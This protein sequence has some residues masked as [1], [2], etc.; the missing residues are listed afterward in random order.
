M[1]AGFK[2]HFCV[3]DIFFDS[4]IF[5]VYMIYKAVCRKFFCH[6]YWITAH[7]KRMAGIKIKTDDF[8]S[9]FME[10]ADCAYIVNKIVRMVFNS[11]LFYSMRR[12]FFGSFFPPR[13]SYGIPLIV[14]HVCKIVWPGICYPYRVRRIGA[15]AGK[16]AHHDYFFYA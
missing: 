4:G 3:S 8:S 7:I 1:I 5:S 6:D 15:A 12:G 10:T 9:F 13:D 16:T 2:Q 11:N 14:K